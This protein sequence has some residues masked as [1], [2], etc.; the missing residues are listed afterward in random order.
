MIAV[1]AALLLLA[2]SFGRDVIWLY[3]TGVARAPAGHCGS[4]SPCLRSL[5]VWVDL[6]APDR[7]WQFTPAAF[8]RIPVEGLVLVA[9][10]LVLPTRPRRI[11]AAIAGILFGLLT[12]DKILNIAFYEEIERA[13]NPVIDWVSI[14]SAV[15]VVRDAIGTTLTNIALAALWIGL[16]LLVARNHRSNDSHHHRGRPAPP[17]ARFAALPLSQPSGG[18][19]RACHCSSSRGPRSPRPAP[20]GWPS[21]RCAP[22]R[23]ALGDPRRFEQ[24]HPPTRPRGQR[25]R[26]G[27]A[28]RIARQGRHHRLRRKLRA[29]RRPGHELL[30][31]S[32][33]RPAPATPP[34]WPAL[35]GPRR[36]PGSPPRPSAGSAG[37]PT[38]P[39]SR[40]C[41]STASSGMP[42]LRRQP[43][44]SPSATPSTRPAGAPSSD[45]PD[46]RRRLAARQVS[47][48]TST[49]ST[50]GATSAT[51]AR[52]F[53][54]A[55]MP[56]QYTLAEFQRL[57]LA[58]A[59]S[60]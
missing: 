12:L 18:C 14:S 26:F 23:S 27:P 48:T 57:E 21:R 17:R 8:A 28:D 59:T 9:V 58:P 4:P 32:R 52:R 42:Q 60:P 15:G 5:L 37:S 34:R 41:G 36:A 51:T 56:D 6:V 31:G 49:S 1:A 50:T 43:A 13:F 44:G 16:I 24:V 38:P 33:R 30:A 29:G 20:P 7:A 45:S 39:C 55:S 11:V 19:A 10:A 25:P 22:L 47:S 46:G 3:R 53:S 35:T 2:E 54:Y 40:G